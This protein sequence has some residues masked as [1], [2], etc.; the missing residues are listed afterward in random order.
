MASLRDG[1]ARARRFLVSEDG[2]SASEYAILLALLVLVAMGTI[3]SVGEGMYAIYDN[4][5]A[6]IPTVE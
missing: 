1:L 5:E 3:Q 2:P 4:I 6:A